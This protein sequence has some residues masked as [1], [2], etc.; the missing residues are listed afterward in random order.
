MS[1]Q[2]TDKLGD[3]SLRSKILEPAPGWL[4]CLY[5]SCFTSYGEHVYKLGRAKDLRQRL[6]GYT[7]SYIQPSHFVCVSGRSFQDSRKAESILFYILR[8]HR[9]SDR[10][11]FF[12]VS[13][14]QVRYV[15]DRLSALS[16]EL[17]D[18]MYLQILRK[19]CPSDILER[20]IDTEEEV[21]WYTKALDY[22]HWLDDFF[23]KFRFR[24]KHPELYHRTGLRPEEED[25]LFSLIYS[26]KF[27]H[28]VTRY[29]HE[30]Q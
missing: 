30:D 9:I 16:D 20:I 8:T 2:L 25:E 29:D 19:V 1:K 28:E 10:R 14:T 24:P 13:S 4:Y 11:E 7:T 3:L 6:H 12:N 5:N 26:I 23:N 22:R 15:I 27:Q 18:E 17:I 21:N